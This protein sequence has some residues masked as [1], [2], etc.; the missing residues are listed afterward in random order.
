MIALRRT[1]IDVEAVLDTVRRQ[2]A[3]A[4]AVFLG[5]V[6]ADPGVRALDYEVFGPMARAKLRE[7]ADAARARFGVLAM[8]IVHR[9]GHVPLGEDAV[10]I[11]C[12]A[13]HR[14][15]AFEACAWTMDEVKRIVPIWKSELPPSRAKARAR[16]RRKDRAGPR[17]P[18]ASPPRR[19]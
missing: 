1:R 7:V 12:S 9:L 2:D 4:V 3:G 13:P 18:R 10:V 16:R 17:R 11:A 14:A 8:S 5:T 6:R 19:G 15:A